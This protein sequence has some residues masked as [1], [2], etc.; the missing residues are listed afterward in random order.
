MLQS[1]TSI[2]LASPLDQRAAARVVLGRALLAGGAPLRFVVRG[3][4]MWPALRRGDV[5]EVEAAS[6]ASLRRGDVAVVRQG[7]VLLAHRVIALL[8]PAEGPRLLRLRGDTRRSAEGPLGERELLGRIR[9]RERRGRVRRLDRGLSRAWG[10]AMLHVGGL[11]A[12]CFDGYRAW[13][14][15]HARVGRALASA[16]VLLGCL[17]AGATTRAADLSVPR[18]RGPLEL[19]EVAR[20]VQALRWTTVPRL[21]GAARRLV[22]STPERQAEALRALVLSA[23]SKGTSRGPVRRYHRIVVGGTVVVVLDPPDPTAIRT[24][25]DLVDQSF[26]I[27][28]GPSAGTV[29]VGLERHER[30]RKGPNLLSLVFE[31]GFG[32]AIKLTE[33]LAPLKS[34]DRRIGG[35]RLLREYALFG[36]HGGV[37]EYE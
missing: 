27:A 11:W 23:G 21:S 16:L 15:A 32:G 19:L 1:V 33:H 28:S 4:S 6:V 2:T 31:P 14:R 37:V 35:P 34:A 18:H 22:G 36:P 30:G 24:Y 20:A 17:L 13:R 29:C 25:G 5:V 10:Q 8:T 12:C 26:I 3:A 7:A 9:Q